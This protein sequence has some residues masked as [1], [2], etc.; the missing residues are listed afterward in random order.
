M[1]SHYEY[2]FFK[3]KIIDMLENL[4][5]SYQQKLIKLVDFLKQVVKTSIQFREM[6]DDDLDYLAVEN[7]FREYSF[8][9]KCENRNLCSLDENGH[10]QLVLPSEHLITGMENE[11]LY[12]FRLADELLRFHRIRSYM[13]EPMYYLNLSNIDYQ[14]N[15]DEILLLETY[16]KSENFADLRIF[17]FSD[18]LKNIPYEL[19]E[20]AKKT[21]VYSNVV[22]L[23]P[24]T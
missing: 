24:E 3:L 17:N 12:Y 18:Y 21:Q 22:E 19:A 5:F 2:R 13:L 1:L 14:I 20:P 23:V 16:I 11:K 9:K 7:H 6:T 4:A 15:D 10:C 8:C